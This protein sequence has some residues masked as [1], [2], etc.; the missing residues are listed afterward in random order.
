M[1]RLAVPMQRAQLQRPLKMPGGRE[2]SGSA[3]ERSAG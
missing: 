3:G 2:M 1:L